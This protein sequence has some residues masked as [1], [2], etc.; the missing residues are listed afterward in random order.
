MRQTL[1]LKVTNYGKHPL[2]SRH[3]LHIMNPYYGIKPQYQ[4]AEVPPGGDCE[5]VGDFTEQTSGQLDVAA[6]GSG[7]VGANSI[8]LTQTVA[9]SDRAVY[10]LL[11]DS[12]DVR[13]AKFVG[14]WYRTGAADQWDP[15]DI[16][17]YIFTRE[18]NFLY[19]NRAMAIDF[20]EAQYIDGGGQP[21]RYM[22]LDL[23]RFTRAA[24]FE[25]DNLSEVW[26]VGWYSE[27]GDNG[28]ILEVDQ[29]EFYTHG[30]GYG[31]ARGN[32]ISIPLADTIH[33]RRGY[34]LAWAETAGRVNIA[35]DNEPAFAGL[36]IDNPSETGL[37]TD[38][39]ISAVP[40]TITVLDA[41]LFDIGTCQIWD[42]DTAAGEILTITAVNRITNEL[43]VAATVAAY[44]IASNARLAMNGDEVGSVRVDVMGDGVANMLCMDGSIAAM[45]GVS[46]ATGA[47]AAP[48]IDDG[49]GNS[50]GIMIGK[51]L[52]AGATDEVIPVLLGMPGTSA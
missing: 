31:P 41:S 32:I 20:F 52:D 19:A 33:T 37:A 50:Q 47:G 40:T 7:R 26:G 12:I 10:M 49:G 15:G 23:T 29:I 38:V 35:I 48:D 9:A 2:Q 46:I 3:A 34:A 21:Y 14:M 24:G 44:T 25:S 28:N 4:R 36:C 27:A 43:T 6:V 30:T 8:R 13:W 45:E 16:A 11:A 5:T 42:D 51:G 1:A 39:A 17:F 22:E 18:G